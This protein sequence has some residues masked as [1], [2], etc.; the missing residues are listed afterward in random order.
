VV[1]KILLQRRDPAGRLGRTATTG[2]DFMDEVDALQHDPAGERVL[3][4][5]WAALSGRTAGFR[6]RGGA[7]RRE[8]LARSSALSS[9]PAPLPSAMASW[10][11]P[12]L[13]RVLGELLA[14]LSSLS[15]YASDGMLSAPI[16]AV[17]D[18]A[19]AGARRTCLATDRWR[20]IHYWEVR[21]ARTAP[22]P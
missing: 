3:G 17:L 1:E 4:E 2:Y 5:A 16:V 8:I 6:R 9:T 12:M 19:A 22:K 7:R 11:A 14:P 20:S 13:R 15:T 21:R 18:R 10:P